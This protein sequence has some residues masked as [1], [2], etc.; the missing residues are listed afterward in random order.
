[1][2]L[3]TEQVIMR[4]LKEHER[5]CFEED[6]DDIKTVFGVAVDMLEADAKCITELEDQIKR[7]TADVEPVR[8]GHWTY[9]NW[10]QGHW[11]NGSDRCRCSECKR[12]FKSDHLNCWWFCPQCGAKMDG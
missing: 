3:T 5:I 12:D 7:L 11:V 2:E 10:E 1:M 6:R 4:L 9:G 8:N